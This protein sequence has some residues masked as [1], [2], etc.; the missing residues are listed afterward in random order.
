MEITLKSVLEK[1]VEE[2]QKQLFQHQINLDFYR[3]QTIIAVG[4]EIQQLDK[5]ILKQQ[6]MIEGSEEFLKF[7]NRR[8]KE[9]NNESKLT[10]TSK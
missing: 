7:L 9:V 1:T 5:L 3:S 2:T 4:Q 8:L 6:M 10:I